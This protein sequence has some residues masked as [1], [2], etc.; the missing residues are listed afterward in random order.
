VLVGIQVWFDWNAGSDQRY[1]VG[2]EE[3]LMLL[4]RADLSLA[5]VSG[6]VLAE[7]PRSLAECASPETHAPV[8]ELK[9]GVHEEVH[10]AIAEL[11][12]NRGRLIRELERLRLR[13][14]GAGTYP[15]VCAPDSGVT[16]VGRYRT[17]ADSMRMLAHRE[18]TM[19]LHVHVGVPDREDAIR[20][21]NGLGRHVPVLLALS[22]NS[23]FSQGRDTGFASA[24]TVIFHA[25]P[26]TGCPRE[27]VSYADYVRGVDPLISSG[28]LP[29]PSFLWWDVR[30]QPALGTV[31]LR[32]ADTQATVLDVAPL[33]AFVQSLARLELEGDPPPARASPEVHAENRFLAARDGLDA[34]FVDQ[35]TR[36]LVPARALVEE[37]VARCAPHARKL[38]C[39]A[40]LELVENLIAANGADRQRSWVR[41]DPDL[42]AVVATLADRFFSPR[43]SP[44]AAVAATIERKD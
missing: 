38:G 15:G 20:V 34:Q 33:V 8:M 4:R 44:L 23:P 29:D 5:P 39:A 12:Q 31:E 35:A 16:T 37:L 26:R 7:I 27:F 9:T 1:T 36:A 10:G 42:R 25:F 19:A 3:E 2:I 13:A 43:I 28:A 14:A 18:P 6:L 41:G 22:A 40:E 17:V 32:A 21:L 30:L 24:R 11:A